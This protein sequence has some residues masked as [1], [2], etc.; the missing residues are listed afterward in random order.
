[1][2][3]FGSV[4]DIL[5]VDDEHDFLDEISDAL[6]YQRLIPYQLNIVATADSGSQALELARSLQPDLIVMDLVMAGLD[7]LET[8]K[9]LLPELPHI[10]V[11]ILSSHL[12]FKD[13]YSVVQAGVRGYLLKGN[14]KQLL[15]GIEQVYRDEPVFPQEVIHSLFQQQF[16]KTASQKSLTYVGAPKAELLSTRE[17]EIL[18]LSQS[19]YSRA[20]IA[21][22]LQ[23]SLSTV[24]TY[25]NRINNKI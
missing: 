11:L 9:I 3:S 1:M 2:S 6:K 17:R 12:D 25:L 7:G 21:D 16:S 4:I 8:A 22:K 19:G 18:S 10:K 23:L 15:K 14:T 13:V 24:R 20:D 5:L